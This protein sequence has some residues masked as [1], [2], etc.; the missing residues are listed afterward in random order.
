MR[1]LRLRG[2]LPE[3]TDKLY[4]V[5]RE[6]I[7]RGTVLLRNLVTSDLNE[8][9]SVVMDESPIT[10][11]PT[12][13]EEDVAVAFERYDLTSAPV[14]DDD[15]HLLGRITIDDVVDVMQESASHSLLA[16]AGLGDEEDIFA[17]VFQTARRRAV[18]L[19]VNLVTAVLASWVI[20]LFE[21]AIEKLVAIGGS[22]ADYCEYGGQ[23]R[24]PD[25]DKCDSRSRC[26]DNLIRQRANRAEE[27]VAGRRIEW[28]DLGTGC[29]I[30]FHSLVPELRASRNRRS[31]DA[32][33]YLRFF[34]FGSH[35]AGTP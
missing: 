21:E 2:E 29:G 28:T 16:P 8:L 23:C 26:G 14:V 4:V 19:G 20:G 18:W 11:K 17:P 13:S 9:I 6:G 34:H 27:R 35:V 10:L 12:D 22:D 25:S 15:G 30:G 3:Y 32:G 33:Q 31:R 24:Y 5:D 1:Y 7:F